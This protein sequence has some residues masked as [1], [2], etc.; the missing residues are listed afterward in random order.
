M[1]NIQQME[2]D[3]MRYSAALE[4]YLKSD[5]LRTKLFKHSLNNTSEKKFRGVN[6]WEVEDTDIADYEDEEDLRDS[7]NGFL[8]T[9][10]TDHP[11]AWAFPTSLYIWESFK[12]S[13]RHADEMVAWILLQAGIT[14]ISIRYRSLEKNDKTW[15]LWLCLQS[16]KG[17]WKFRLQQNIKELPHNWSYPEVIIEVVGIANFVLDQYCIDLR[18]FRTDKHESEID[19][20]SLI[21]RE[22]VSKLSKKN[23]TLYYKVP[24]NFRSRCTIPT[25]L[26]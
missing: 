6:L 12:E 3:Q 10:Y 11:D 17:C 4:G 15:S 21:E 24:D 16:P 7:I 2:L 13:V 20:I 25:F 9:V 5:R 18:A 23:S 1:F 19:R 26:N 8:E 14:D 22:S